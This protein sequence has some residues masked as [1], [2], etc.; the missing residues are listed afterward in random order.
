MTLEYT[1]W[2]WVAIGILTGIGYTVFVHLR[3]TTPFYDA[4]TPMLGP[5]FASVIG[6]T[7]AMMVCA[8]VWPVVI[9]DIV[10]GVWRMSHPRKRKK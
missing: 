6:M 4:L 3:G 1:F 7:I 10:F 8:V 9:W 2:A 5:F